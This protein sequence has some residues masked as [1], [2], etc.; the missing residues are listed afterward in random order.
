MTDALDRWPDWM[1]FGDGT[2][3]INVVAKPGAS[4]REIVRS[5]PRGVVIALTSSPEKG[6]ANEELT[7]VIADTVHVA[8]SRVKVVRGHTS[9][10]KVVRVAT[11]SPESVARELMQM[12]ELAER[13]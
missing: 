1:R 3:T 9:R 2:L 5:E 11:G 8:Q 7:G 6:K 13:P 12:L 4:R 10:L